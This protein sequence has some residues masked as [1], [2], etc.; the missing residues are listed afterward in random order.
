MKK[1]LLVAGLLCG[2]ASGAQASIIPVLG[3]VTPAGSNFQFSYTG[4]LAGD[5]GVE[6]GSRLI[7]FDFA[8]YVPGSIS[9]A[10]ANI[11][12]S[13]ELTSTLAPPFPAD[14]NPLLPNLVFTWEGGPFQTSGGP[15]P[16]I[17]FTGLSAVSTFSGVTLD[18][19][20][21]QT[22]TNNGAATGEPAFNQGFVGVPRVAVPEP[23]AWALMI[24]G[25]GGIGGV[26]RSRRRA[27]TVLA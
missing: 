12:S 15:F 13:V 20:S 5:Q 1:L 26:F 14:D 24:L 17:D 21:A 2:L 10:N 7:I 9:A 4:T 3:S 11:V 16:D 6:N 22:V 27:Q 19:F 18:G 23:A 25:F 8:G